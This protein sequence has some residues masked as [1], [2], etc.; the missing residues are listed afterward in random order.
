L[1]KYKLQ[2]KYSLDALRQATVNKKSFTM[3]S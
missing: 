2:Y 3:S 1:L